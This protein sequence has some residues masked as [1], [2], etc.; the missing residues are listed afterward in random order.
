MKKIFIILPLI[1]LIVGCQKDFNNV[2]DSSQPENYRVIGV[3]TPAQFTY[4]P[5]DSLI[6]ISAQLNTSANIQKV[7]FNIL[8]SDQT[9]LNNSPVQL[10]DNGNLSQNGDT[11]KGDL[12]YS[13]KFPLSH[14]YPKGS[15]EIEIYISGNSGNTTLAAVHSFNFNNGQ[16]NVPPVLSG[17]SMPDTVSFGVSFIFS[18][19]ASDQNG[20]SDISTVFYKLYRPDGTMVTNSQ[21]IS[22]YPLSDNGDYSVTGDITAGDGTYTNKLQFPSGQP[23]GSWKFT[24]QAKDKSGALSNIV[25]HNLVVK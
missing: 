23:T 21:G 6:T 2:V 22:E 13:N 17:L 8:S 7:V 20:L 15:Y 4:N 25:T 24:F 16:A 12:V 11:V 9:Q 14:Y 1:L 19:K 18:I 10:F 3:Y 5:G